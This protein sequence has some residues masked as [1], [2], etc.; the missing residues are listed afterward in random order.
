MNDLTSTDAALHAGPENGELLPLVLDVDG[1]LLKTDLT[2]ESLIAYIR[3]NPLRV[4]EVLGWLPRGRSHMKRELASRIDID[5]DRLPVNA[6]VVVMAEAAAQSGR[7]VYL[8]SA[9]DRLLV[10]RL[11]H[12]FPFVSGVL[13][14]DGTQNLKGEAKAQALRR[15]FPNGFDYAGDA[16]ADLA[17]WRHADTAILV[18][19]SPRLER[20][21]RVVAREVSQVVSP[22]LTGALLRSL[23]LH[24]WSKNLLV[25]APIILGGQ[26]GHWPA[27]LA[28][29][30]AFVALG[31]VASA[32]YLI[33][34]ILDLH[35]DRRHW[36]KRERPIASGLLPL[37]K[38][39]A[40]SV[41]ALLAGFAI[42][43]MISW[44]AAAALAAY[45][46]LTLFYSLF[47]K[48][49][50]L[51]DGLVLATLYTSRLALGVVAAQVPPSP[52]LFVFSMFIFASLSF[53]K[54]YTELQRVIEKQ[55]GDRIAGRGYRIEDVPLVLAL[56]MA[57]GMAAVV[58]T[59]FYIIEDAFLQS[60]YGR[61]GWLWGFPP[62]MFLFVCRMWLVSVRG[63][64]S[65]DPIEFA[66]RDLPSQA[67][68]AGLLVCFGF[69]WLG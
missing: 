56:G 69:A 55:G 64:M 46:A 10:E 40:A 50:P 3:P 24:Q 23:R 13:A 38:A 1:T 62:L 26:L 7:S 35:D 20:R 8:A 12:R 28:T 36:S 32:T 18:N 59:I 17:V 2:L 61:T 19:V 41:L 29:A 21:A 53:A 57:T 60:F 11:K 52:W 58:V 65:D 44:Q 63:E 34:D 30:A 39:L 42:G 33:N 48:R 54:R 15:T 49:L 45:V 14:S 9:S 43:A 5:V 6:E 4:L 68:L 37:D 27:L 47:L 22:P 25:F 66:L 31:L 16:G 51:I 67:V